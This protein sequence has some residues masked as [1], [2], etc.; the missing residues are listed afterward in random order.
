MRVQHYFMYAGIHRFPC[1]PDGMAKAYAVCN[2]MIE[3]MR[4]HELSAEMDDDMYRMKL[5]QQKG[6][7][8]S[9]YLSGR[10]LGKYYAGA[11][12]RRLRQYVESTLHQ[13]QRID[14]KPEPF[15]FRKELFSELVYL[16]YLLKEHGGAYNER[17]I[18]VA[19]E[20]QE[21]KTLRQL[22]DWLK[23]YLMSIVM[24]MNDENLNPQYILSAI[25]YIELNYMRDLSLKEV[26]DAVYLNPWYFSSQFKK[27]V[28]L[29]FSEYLN[30]VRCRIAKDFLRQKD[31]KVYQVA[32]MVGFQDAA[33]FSTVFKSIEKMSPKEF[34]KTF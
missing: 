13:L 24:C 12:A 9:A 7:A 33:Y 26:A 11:D 6:F 30:V 20:M 14:L 31:L 1:A 4:F 28:N 17:Q 32:E 19:Q 29:S 10:E 16:D 27:H 22:L 8:V 5:E 25:R 23:N 15:R 2:R 21:A 18:D 34:Q 3:F